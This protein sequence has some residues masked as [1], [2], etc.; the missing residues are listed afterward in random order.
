MT[1]SMFVPIFT[2]VWTID[3]PDPLLY[4]DTDPELGVVV[5]VKVAPGILDVKLMFV[6]WLLHC[7]EVSSEFVRSG[8]GFTVTG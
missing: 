8:T 5:Q 3:K 1:V 7:E 4:P 6:V 2:K